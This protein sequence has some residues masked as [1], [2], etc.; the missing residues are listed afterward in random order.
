MQYSQT[1][2][3][4]LLGSLLCM[5]NSCAT[6]GAMEDLGN[7]FLHHGIA[8]PVSHPR[9]I[10]AT[11]DGEGRNVVLVWLFDR[12]G[13]YALLAIDAE[14]GRSIEY[15]MPF[16]PRGDCPY[17][18]ILSSRNKFYT[19]F[20]SH[21]VEFDPEKHAFTFYHATAPQMAMSMTEDDNG[22][23]WSATYPQCGVVSFNPKT[24][25]FVDYGHIYKQNWREYPRY[26][27]LDDTGWVY[28]GIG[29]TATQIV[30]FNPKS[31]EVRPMIPESERVKGMAYVVRDVNGKVYGHA[32]SDVWYEFYRGEKR[33]I[34]K[35]K[36]INAKRIIAGSQGLFHRQFPDGKR[37]KV[38]D[39]INRVLVVEDPKTGK[40][41]R[42]TFD[43]SSEGAHIMGLAVAPNGTICG[44]TAFPMRFF[45]YD[46]KADRW[47]N[48]PCYGQWNTVARQ[49]DRFFVGG[50][51][52]G[53][54]LEWDPSRKW[55][56]TKKGS[57][58]SNPRFL[59]QCTP[60][61]NHGLD[62]LLPFFVGTHLRDGS[63]SK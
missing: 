35:P 21:F 24:R 25:E 5:M 36:R 58:E 20:A 8:T 18:S 49:G 46:P 26:I 17:A 33:R 50:Y 1:L 51:G 54:L 47:V 30:A 59:T 56:P 32:G 11:V 60:V 29:Y 16:N 44:G 3:M 23:I 38:C 45:S 27:A 41:K 28:I 6:F 55:V 7:G 53:F 40:S 52:G 15:P 63:H 12:R 31:K 39:L 62:S 42:V 4:T 37:V 9:G 13:G 2:W 57:K 10:V 48:R 34:E 43:Y 14:T 61:I 22:I 19:H